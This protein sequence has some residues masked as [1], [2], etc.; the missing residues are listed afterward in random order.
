MILFQLFQIIYA[1]L[2]SV[3]IELEVFEFL[4]NLLVI[5]QL[6]SQQSV[7]LWIFDLIDLNQLFF[8]L[9]FTDLDRY[10]VDFLLIFLH[11]DDLHEFCLFFVVIAFEVE[12]EITFGL[13]V[14][15]W[16]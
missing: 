1:N 12:I 11:F 6:V 15:L 4:I 10:L 8:L 2:L 16:F 14:L 5:Q 13:F 3:D 7:L 9:V